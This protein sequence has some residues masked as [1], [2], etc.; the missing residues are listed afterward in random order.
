VYLT[1]DQVKNSP[2]IDTDRR[3]RVNRKWAISGITDTASIGAAEALGAGYTGHH[4]GRP[5]NHEGPRAV[6]KWRQRLDNPHLRSVN[7]LLRYYVHARTATS[8]T[9]MAFCSRKNLAIRYLIVNTSNWWLGH[10]C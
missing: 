8:A 2:D 7:A 4:T 1:C 6:R 10:E 5:A 3:S 9:S